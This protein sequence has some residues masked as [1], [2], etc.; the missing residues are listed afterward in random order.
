MRKYAGFLTQQSNQNAEL[1]AALTV[2]EL[3]NLFALLDHVQAEGDPAATIDL[4]TN[5]FRLLQ[6]AGRPRLLKRV[7]Q[8][9]DAASVAMG[10][11]WNHAP[12]EAKRTRIEQQLSGGHF[13]EALEGAEQLLD[14]ARTAGEQAYAGA[15]YDLALACFLLARVLQTVGGS[16]QALPLLD[17]A[18]ARFEA[19][20]K[21]RDDKGA[22]GM[23]SVCFSEQG[24]CLLDVGRLDEAAAA[25]EDAIR[26]DE[27]LDDERG[28][29]VGEGQL[30]SVRILQRRFPEALVAYA[31]ARERFTRLDEPG[32]VA[33]IWHQTGM[34]Y[35]D[36]G[37]PEAAEDAYRKSLALEVQLG[38]V[39][40]QAS[41]LVQ[42]GNL[43][44]DALD[45]PE[46]A[47]A[48]YRQA[49]DKSVELGDVAKEGTRR[50]NLA[51]TLQKLRRLN[52]A[53]QEIRR[54]IKCKEPYGHAAEP[55]KTWAILAN[56]ETDDGHP[57]AA[58]EARGKAI[59]CYLAY[60]RDGGENHDPDGRICL[61][62]TQSLLAGDPDQAAT[63]QQRAAD[64]ELPAWLGPFAQ[65]LQAIVSGHRDRTL[66]DNPELHFTSVAEILFLLET[67]DQQ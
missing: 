29:A 37:Q 53:R 10:D 18:R 45:R 24:E 33:V 46:E 49:V 41:T 12:F 20:A 59:D 4:A 43:Y 19:I 38:N 42:L 48:F 32:M 63:L 64:P 1:A 11:A 17:G 15:D 22:E 62:V 55:W 58:A 2:L 30:G 5:L 67:L 61:D 40:G 7:G 35:Q 57:A 26:R 39:P 23:A 28:V 16:E 51:N 6:N 13:R 54:A 56:I 21:E 25:Y 50:S 27:Q 47:A 36:A 52:E 44:D 34:A 31:Q 3:P 8:V 66:A 9:R 65:A 60:R 14:R